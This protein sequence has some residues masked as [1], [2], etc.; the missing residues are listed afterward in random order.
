MLIFPNPAGLAEGQFAGDRVRRLPRSTG[1]LP[2][3]PGRSETY[4]TETEQFPAVC[5]QAD[6]QYS[7][8]IFFPHFIYQLRRTFKYT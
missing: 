3:F 6:G 1:H 8:I 4:T 7:G 2:S 5:H